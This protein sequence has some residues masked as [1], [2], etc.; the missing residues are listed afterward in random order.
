MLN[1]PCRV[2][3]AAR[4]AALARRQ[5]KE[6][7]FEGASAA[8]EAEALAAEKAAAEAAA[9]GIDECTPVLATVKSSNLY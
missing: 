3:F 6:D 9:K 1:E 2:G 4:K 7:K 5:K 8:R